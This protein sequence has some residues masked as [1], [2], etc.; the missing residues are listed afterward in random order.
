MLKR[1]RIFIFMLLT[2][3][4]LLANKIDSLRIKLSQ[5]RSDSAKI[6]LLYKTLQSPKNSAVHSDSLIQVIAGYAKTT[7][8]K[9]SYF[10]YYSIAKYFIDKD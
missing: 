1:S 5:A 6:E 2:I 8:C 10:S 7:D 3:S 4:S 9:A